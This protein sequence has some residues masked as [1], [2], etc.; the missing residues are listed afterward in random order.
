MELIKIEKD[1][2]NYG[3]DN[4][5]SKQIAEFERQIKAIKEQE[6]ALK[7]KILSEM[8]AN[9]LVKIETDDL[10]ISY[11]A[12]TDRETFDS[13]TFK[14]DNQDLYDEYV[15]VTPIKSSIRIKVKEKSEEQEKIEKIKEIIN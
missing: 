2:L 3:L 10:V 4:S 1:G 14:A 13:K 6:D 15:K 8:E 11:I 9:N 12:P 5:I 7:E